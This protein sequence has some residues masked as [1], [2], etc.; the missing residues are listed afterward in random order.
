[1]RDRIVK[2]F[3]GFAVFCLLSGFT[4]A[5]EI[6]PDSVVPGEIILKLSARTPLL[7]GRSS[8]T[9]TAT[10]DQTL[11]RYGIESV[12]PM[13]PSGK[14]RRS[15]LPDI[16][17]IYRATYNEDVSPLA[18][19][20]ALA[21]LPEVV[22]A[23][24]NYIRRQ[25]DRPNDTRFNSQWHLS[26][27]S[28]VAAWS[29][30]HGDSTV[31][32][33]IV[34]SGTDLDHPDL[35]A[36]IWVNEAELNGLSGSDDDNNGYVDDI[37]G[38][39]FADDDN[40]PDNAVP[41]NIHGTH[42]AGLA[43]A[44]TDN[45]IGVAG[46]AWNVKM[47]IT[48]HGYDDDTPA[49]VNGYQGIVY[50]AELG[51]HVINCSWGGGGYSQY[52]ADAI[53]YASGLGALVV[54][55][56]GNENSDIPS[57]PSA[58]ENVFSVAATNR[59]DQRADFS[60]F[61][62]WVDGATP[63]VSVLS[64]LP[65]ESYGQA[66]GT[67]MSS[68]V[69]AGAAALVKSF[70]T[71]LLPHQLARRLAGTA[72]NIDSN[73]P[74]FVGLLG[75]GRFNA[76]NALTYDESQFAA[77]EPKLMMTKTTISEGSDGNGNGVYDKGESANVTV[78]YRSF[79]LGA[80][81]NFTVRLSSDDPDLS[82]TSATTAD[83]TVPADTTFSIVEELSFTVAE[84][85]EGHMAEL[86]LEGA[87][88]GSI[89]TSDTLSIL[90]GKTPILLVDDD[91]EDCCGDV[92]V[93]GFY[94]GILEEN[95]VSYGVWDHSRQGSPSAETLKSFP[96]VIWFTEWDFPSLDSL[97]RAALRAY[98]DSG[99]NLYLSGQ[100]LG[101]DLNENPGTDDQT[102][103]FN[104]YLR[105]DW[106]GD[107]AGTRNVEGV[108]GDPI[109]HGLNFTLYQPGL[110]KD[111][112][113]PDWFSPKEGAKPIF[114]YDNGKAMGLRYQ[115]DYRLVYTGMGLEA[116]GSGITSKAPDDINDIQRTV[117]T[118]ILTYLNFVHHKRLTDTETVNEDF[119]ISIDVAGDTADVA[120]VR[121]YYMTDSM[122]D[123]EA[124]EMVSGDGR[125]FK[126][127]IPAPGEATT[128]S[129]YI[130]SV[131]EY[132]RWTNPSGAPEN[133]FRFYAGPD[134]VPP[135][136]S[137]ITELDDRIDRT[138]SAEIRAFAQDNIS[139]KEVTIETWT[140]NDPSGTVRTV[141]MELRGRIWKAKI[142]WADVPGN[143]TVSYRIKVT[144][145]SSNENV[146]R[147]E[148]FTFRIVN[149]AQL[150]DWEHLDLSKWDTGDG[151][152]AFFFN[153]SIGW[154]MN[155]S[156]QES[157]RDNSVNSL[158]MLNYI[159]LSSYESAYLS[160]WELSMLEE[161]KDWGC[162]DLSAG[163][164]WT[165]VSCI[166]GLSVVREEEI[167]DLSP[168]LS[169]GQVKVRFQ[170]ITD[171]QNAYQGWYLGNISLLVDTTLQMTTDPEAEQLPA[172]FSLE[173]NYPNPFNPATTIAFS[174]A[175][176]GD[177]RLTVYDVLGREVKVLMNEAL[178]RGR[179]EV[180]WDG[181]N[182]ALESVPSGV[183]FACL[184]AGDRS[185]TRKLLLLR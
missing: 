96:V 174:L 33:G 61:G 138:G 47:L 133:A 181:T 48:K 150:T 4:V 40:N 147:S 46:V 87:V 59:N 159:D 167:V 65:D 171:E 9:G 117:L 82:V 102:T 35:E 119:Q 44:V 60:N 54:V 129:Y 74:D 135:Q 178:M 91:W 161:E 137:F 156:P 89:V 58:Y 126:G 184:S 104:D 86:V 43:N 64:T 38:W 14:T 152:G 101:W 169:E 71:D 108:L 162:I 18:V 179:H 28:A 141:P 26:K 151:W 109:S 130:E 149:Y 42:V 62:L 85:A 172:S 7:R 168:Y 180:V 30:S 52:E 23:E 57:Y 111:L 53:N 175:E 50:A 22:Y 127:T 56:S 90:I 41:E 27:I 144:D 95:G 67:S 164:G 142:D 15:D 185:A 165:T 103:F 81:E 116:F 94:R 70:Y 16:S 2:W 31:I 114:H 88:D 24:P 124:A 75:T 92:N 12:R 73:N 99:G 131:H 55:A 176:T 170:V 93:D 145:S 105:A 69:A 166:T 77:F 155:D 107:D 97:D 173:Q 32:I 122:T 113:Y 177:V 3:G 118:R 45:E 160:F 39:D 140:S 112:Q 84:E 72:D 79:S 120:A 29:I 51:A 17:R 157:Y 183:Y 34:D 132:Y 20:G 146:D 19:A 182:A 80:T 153:P 110:Q 98:M 83:W 78:T 143:T 63:G 139:V 128:I 8:G 6:T 154:L 163:H 148:V 1:M 106:G 21:A 5:E 136:S 11:L 68:P 66:S 125:R 49:I 10:V 158:T 76:K 134:T 121:L 37:R 36:N 100:D 123:Y 115:G 25:Y 13:F